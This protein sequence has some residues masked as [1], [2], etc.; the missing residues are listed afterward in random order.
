MLMIDVLIGVGGTLLGAVVGARGALAVSRE[1]RL[2]AQREDV[3]RAL[4]GYLGALYPS[5]AELR[6]LPPAR[7]ESKLESGLKRLERDDVRW[8]RQRRREHLLYGDRH[9]ELAAK[10]AAAA[11]ELQVRPMPDALRAA[12]D[13]AN[14]YVE[15]LGE[16][17]TPELLNE[18]AS[19]YADLMQGRGVLDTWRPPGR[20]G[21]F[22][23]LIRPR[24]RGLDSPHER[25]EA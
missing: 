18:W 1:D 8:V 19:V 10:L 21:L 17:R 22:E 23:R 2:H 20:A 5:V 14:D 3:R 12:F 6:E 16:Q 24:H 9:R 13:R 15:R 25:S 7:P 11:A 4:A